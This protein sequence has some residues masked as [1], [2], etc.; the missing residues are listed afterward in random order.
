MMPKILVVTSN[1]VMAFGGHLVIAESLL[2]AL[3]ERGFDADLRLTPQNRFGRQGSAYLATALA[4]LT[5]AADDT[6]VDQI[7]SMRFPSFAAGHPRHVCWLNHTM[8]EYYD[9]WPKFSESLSTRALLK[10]TVRRKVMH[11]ADRYFL[12]RKVTKVFAQSQLVRER[13]LTSLRVDS[14]VLYPPPPRREYRCQAYEPY[15]VAISRLTKL[16]RLDL[17]L[18]ALAR[19]AADGARCVV[20]GDGEARAALQRQVVDLGLD[21][22]VRL[23][24][25]VSDRVLLDHLGNC[26]AACFVPAGEDFGLVTLEAFASHKSVITCS[27]SGGPAELVKDRFNGLVVEPTADALARAIG[28]VMGDQAFAEALGHNAGRTAAE[29]TWDKAIA[30]LVLPQN[31]SLHSQ[32]Q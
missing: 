9:L 22:R 27:D 15:L 24:G 11:T 2:Q 17:L 21:D 25:S 19:P 5:R 29:I 12:G 6:P 10:E 14:E 18:E 30:S 3:K 23:L 1:P 31:E 16:K 26:R 13:L 20:I 7:I 8:R 4:D 28:E 32:L